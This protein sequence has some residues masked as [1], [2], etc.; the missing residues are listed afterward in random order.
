MK[1]PM[2][3]LLAL[4][5]VAP[6]AYAQKGP[7]KT[8]ELKAL[9]VIDSLGQ[10]VGRYGVTPTFATYSVF[11]QAVFLTVN[12]ILTAVPLTVVEGGTSNNRLGFNVSTETV[13]FQG[14]SCLGTPFGIFDGLQGAG[15]RVNITV[16]GTSGHTL[17][18]MASEEPWRDVTVGST[19]TNGG[20]CQPFPPTLRNVVPLLPPVDLNV[21][22][23][24]P[25]MIR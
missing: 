2:S 11:G 4:I 23:T 10:T 13:M 25:F 16:R 24:P 1:L 19:I 12:D 5:L 9:T 7:G 22:Y 20:V 18:F 17:L 8:Q 14:Q 6:L 15:V 3:A 21:L